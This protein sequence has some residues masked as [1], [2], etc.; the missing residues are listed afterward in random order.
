MYAGFARSAAVAA[1]AAP[2]I[3]LTAPS[4]FADEPAAPNVDQPTVSEMIQPLR[5]DVDS[6][7]IWLT[8]CVNIP[9]PGSAT[10]NWCWTI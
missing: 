7:G 9:T 6:F 2:L 4:A 3:M 5:K 1:V 8:F 10:L